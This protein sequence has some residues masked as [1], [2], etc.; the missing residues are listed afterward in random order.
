MISNFTIWFVYFFYST[1]PEIILEKYLHLESVCFEE[2]INFNVLVMEK[3]EFEHCA[4]FYLPVGKPFRT[5]TF[6]TPF[7]KA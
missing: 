7:E 1:I 3:L 6:R 5:I 4:N 2:M